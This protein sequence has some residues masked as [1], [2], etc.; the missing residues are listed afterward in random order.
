MIFIGILI[1]LVVGAMA[2]V[3][4]QYWKNRKLLPQPEALEKD[5]IE[6]SLQDIIRLANLNTAMDVGYLLV[7]HKIHLRMPDFYE[8]Y[9]NLVKREKEYYFNELT[10]IFSR[11]RREYVRELLDRYAGLSRQD[12]L[13]LLMCEMQLDNKTM[14]RIMGLSLDTLKKR[15]T[16]LKAK[17]CLLT[18]VKLDEGA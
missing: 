9:Q 17:M 11:N 12:V 3:S 18:E 10:D 5:K 8:K 7:E 14:A 1:G 4:I 16:R 6:G 15:K 13:L 2:V